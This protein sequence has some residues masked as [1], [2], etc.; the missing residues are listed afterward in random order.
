[1]EIIYDSLMEAYAVVLEDDRVLLLGA[2]TLEE[3][4]Q[5]VELMIENGEHLL[6][7]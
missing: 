2:E 5:E 6:Y 1:M 4:Q 3:A 7:G